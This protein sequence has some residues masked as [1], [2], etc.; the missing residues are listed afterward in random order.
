MPEET[1]ALRLTAIERNPN[2]YLPDISSAALQ[3]WLRPITPIVREGDKSG[4]RL[5]G[6]PKKGPPDTF[7]ARIAQA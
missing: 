3:A 2:R 6:G 4:F 5:R 1:L 7:S